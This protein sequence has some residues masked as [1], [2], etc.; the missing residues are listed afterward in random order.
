MTTVLIT[1]AN[2]GIGY[3]LAETLIKRGDRVIAMVRDPFRLPDLLKT[4]PREQMMVIGME[5][6]D[7]R[8][9]R[10]RSRLMPW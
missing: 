10:S 6:T 1:G 2:R 9:V 3:A 8:S 4:A 7:D 5:V